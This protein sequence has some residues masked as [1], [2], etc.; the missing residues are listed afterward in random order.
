MHVSQWRRD[1]P[2]DAEA[3]VAFFIARKAH[4]KVERDENSF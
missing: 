1:H 2:K 4:R 3:K